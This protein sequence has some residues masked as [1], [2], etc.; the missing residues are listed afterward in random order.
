MAGSGEAALVA[1]TYRRP[2]MDHRTAP[3]GLMAEAAAQARIV[4]LRE[5][6]GRM[7]TSVWALGDYHAFAKATV[8][9]L[10]PVLV[11]AC[12]I[13]AG[14]R[15]LDVAAGPRHR[16]NPP[17]QTGGVLGAEGNTPPHKPN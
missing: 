15:V 6:S 11:E 13:S 17:A 16:A 5:R 8:W 2:R 10:G 9:E 14:Q 3:R 1:R 7:T 4:E 12:G